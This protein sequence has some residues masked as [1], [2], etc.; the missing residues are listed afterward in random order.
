M[1][2][3]RTH[4][5]EGV[6]SFSSLFVMCQECWLTLTP[7]NRLPFYKQLW[8]HWCSFECDIP[9]E[10]IRAAVLFEVEPIVTCFPPSIGD[11]V[12]GYT[13]HGGYY[14]TIMELPREV[15]EAWEDWNNHG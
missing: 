11:G 4:D 1:T 14:K 15:V 6:P 5:H 7:E 9:W 10:V 3:Y 8:I 2:P 12:I 13:V